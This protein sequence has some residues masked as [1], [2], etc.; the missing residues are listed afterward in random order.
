M[1]ITSGH[2]VGSKSPSLPPFPV[3]PT[4]RSSPSPSSRRRSGGRSPLQP[5]SYR[6]ISTASASTSLASGMTGSGGG[7]AAHIHTHGSLSTAGSTS[8]STSSSSPVM[9]S[10]SH[11]PSAPLEGGTFPETPFAV[12]ASSA[13]T[14]LDALSVLKVTSNFAH[15]K[16]PSRLLRKLMRIVLETAGSSRGALV[17][18]DPQEDSWVVE[19]TTNVDTNEKTSS[20]SEEDAAE[21][22]KITASRGNS[23]RIGPAVATSHSVPPITSARSKH[24]GRVSSDVEKE[25]QSAHHSDASR[26]SSTGGAEIVAAGGPKLRAGVEGEAVEDV[27]PAT[28][29]NYVLA[30]LETLVL[31]NLTPSSYEFAAFAVS[32]C[33]MR[34]ARDCNAYFTHIELPFCFVI[35]CRAIHTS[36]ITHRVVCSACRY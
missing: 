2:T 24:S 17:L 9:L 25:S 21:G 4:T 22:R 10:P 27:L 5:W 20:S 18:K 14:S 35:I 12:D 26:S 7:A 31:T 16:S 23:P 6:T 36:S 29:F 13:A 30:S 11:V 28:I 1:P 19:L 15:E 34:C 32:R 8:S 33:M 3:P